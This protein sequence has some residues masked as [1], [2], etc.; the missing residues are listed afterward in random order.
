MKIESEKYL[1]RKLVKDVKDIGGWSLK[2]LS[3]HITGLPDRINL[4]PGGYIVFT[5]VKTT[6]RKPSKIQLSI[7]KKIRD[8]GFRVETIETSEQIRNIIRGYV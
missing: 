8:L 3:T 6:K 4:F 2:L 5:E 7:H 1:E